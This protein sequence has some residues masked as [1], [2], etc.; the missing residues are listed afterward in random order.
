MKGGA[1]NRMPFSKELNNPKIGNAKDLQKYF[2]FYSIV[3]HGSIEPRE[4][5]TLFIVPERT[6]IMFTT[7]AGEPTQKIKPKVDEILNQFRYK[8]RV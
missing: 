5:G 7:R 1:K 6:Y 8:F 2:E 3:G 4:T